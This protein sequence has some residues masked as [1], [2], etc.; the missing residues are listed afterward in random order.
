MNCRKIG[1]G[2]T[3]SLFLC[4]SRNHME[5]RQGA[6]ILSPGISKEGGLRRKG[7]IPRG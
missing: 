7:V 2:T 3:L 1:G 5:R 6:L 4:E